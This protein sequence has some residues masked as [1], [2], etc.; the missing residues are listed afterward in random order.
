[1]YQGSDI[2]LYL[3]THYRGIISELKRCPKLIQRW[4]CKKYCRYMDT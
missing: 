3:C 2:H 1:M 4:I